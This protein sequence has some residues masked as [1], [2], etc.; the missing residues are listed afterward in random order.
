MYTVEY[1]PEYLQ[2][3]VLTVHSPLHMYT[4]THAATP[5]RPSSGAYMIQSLIHT[6]LLCD[7]D[8]VILS[9]HTI[10]RSSKQPHLPT[11]HLPT[12]HLPTSTSPPPPPSSQ[13]PKANSSIYSYHSHP[14]TSLTELLLLCFIVDRSPLISA[15]Q[16][17]TTLGLWLAEHLLLN[18]LDRLTFPSTFNPTSTSR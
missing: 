7:T 6:E 9:N 4:C 1:S 16:L 13:A 2:S 11:S 14:L 18:R 8:T 3:T 15:L 12:S 17:S 10:I 5:S